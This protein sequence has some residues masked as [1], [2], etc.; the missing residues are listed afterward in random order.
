MRIIARGLLN[1]GAPDSPR[2]FSIFP[3]LSELADG[4]LLAAYRVGSTKD[5]EDETIELRESHDFGE[6]WSEPR[7]PFPNMLDGARGTLRVLYITTLGQ[8]L[9]A[10]AMWIDR[11]SYPGQPLFHPETQGCLPMRILVAESHDFGATWTG[12]RTVETHPDIGPPSLT[13]PVL[14]F[15]S[16]RLALSIESNKNYLD[17]TPWL[18]KVTYLYSHDNGATWN[19]SLT[20]LQDPTGRLFHWDQRAGVT[21]DGTLVTYTWTFDSIG[22]TYLNIPRRISRDEGRSWSEAVDLGISD[23]PAH[24]AILADG[25]VVLAW[26]DRFRTQTIRVR[27][28]ERVDGPFLE[29]SDLVLFDNKGATSTA[30]HITTDETLADMARWTFGLPYC[31]ALK[32]GEVMVVYY[33]PHGSGTAVHW[34]RLAT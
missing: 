25:R 30:K 23:Q 5:S 20:I 16:G 3:C 21:P 33:A 29:S 31:E 27:M 34:V 15:P 7:S 8:T 10:A 1:A 32:N 26:V 24:P 13:N 14:R 18:Q 9:L 19:D 12:W 22:G 6:H 4:R 17:A 11:E 28:S 2:A